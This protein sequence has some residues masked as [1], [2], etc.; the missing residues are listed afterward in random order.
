MKQSSRGSVAVASLA[1]RCLRAAALE[2]VVALQLYSMV[3]LRV[4]VLPRPVRD[5]RPRR[6]RLVEAGGELGAQRRLVDLG[7]AE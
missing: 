1:E 6:R 3:A 4:H 5:E 7:H 2:V